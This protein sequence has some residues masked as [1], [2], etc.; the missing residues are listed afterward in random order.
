MTTLYGKSD[1][2]F[3]R[4][5]ALI[6]LLEITQSNLKAKIVAEVQIDLAQYVEQGELMIV[7][8]F[9][10][11]LAP[12]NL[13]VETTIH[14]K[15][16]EEQNDRDRSPELSPMRSSISLSRANVDTMTT[17]KGGRLNVAN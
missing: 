13:S 9:K 5:I 17:Y 7:Y 14:V 15:Q 16:V 11:A 2:S 6:R 4:K 12:P 3:S 10:S 8:P 1:G